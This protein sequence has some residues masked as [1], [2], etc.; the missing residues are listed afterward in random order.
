VFSSCFVSEVSA[1][2]NPQVDAMEL[3]AIG[4]IC[5][6]IGVALA[7]ETDRDRAAFGIRA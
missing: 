4:K 6:R 5:R 2:S 3:I 1:L 7:G